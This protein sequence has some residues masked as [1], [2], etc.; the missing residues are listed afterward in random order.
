MSNKDI[1]CYLSF[2][3]VGIFW[4]QD[5]RNSAAKEGGQAP[6]YGFERRHLM[7]PTHDVPLTELIELFGVQHQQAA[8][9]ANTN[10][11]NGQAT[12][13]GWRG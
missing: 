6:R 2:T 13:D 11:D 4:H 5:Q 7:P 8:A 10:A 3:S 12:L 1:P 9:N